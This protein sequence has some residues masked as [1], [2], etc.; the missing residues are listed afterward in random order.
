MKLGGG[1]SKLR[2][3]RKVRRGRR[4]GPACSTF[5]LMILSSYEIQPL[6]LSLPCCY[7]GC[8]LALIT[9]S[10]LFSVSLTALL[11]TSLFEINSTIYG[12]YPSIYD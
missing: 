5:F 12:M 6:F 11:F 2:I 10:E 4:V 7:V 1:C 9:L 3:G 8:R